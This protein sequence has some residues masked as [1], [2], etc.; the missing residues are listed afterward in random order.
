MKNK[1]P[2]SKKKEVDTKKLIGIDQPFD[3]EEVA[4]ITGP[5]YV[6][7]LRRNGIAVLPYEELKRNVPGFK[8]IEDRC[9]WMKAGIINFRNCDYD[10]DCNNCPFDHAMRSAMGEKDTPERME[11]QASWVS[12]L[13][14]RY[15]VAEKPCIHFKSGRIESPKE[16]AGNYE[17]YACHVHE[18]LYAQRQIQTIKKP[19]YTRVSGFQI[20]DNYYH[21]FGHSWAHMEHDG[22][23]RIGVD[24][25]ISKLLGPADVI[26]LPPV[27]VL[28]KQGEIGWL[29]TRNGL[30]APLQSPLSGTVCAVNNRIKEQPAI[31][32]QE[33][34]EAGWLFL[35]DPAS[36]KLNLKGLYYGK[37]CFQW[38]EKENQNLLEYLDPQYEQL[39]ATGGE[40]VDDIYTRLSEKSWYRLVC[41][42]LHTA[43]KG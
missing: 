27:G 2:K 33:P 38:I 43:E 34:Y 4:A 20:A 8:L 19:T 29:M 18:M 23:V 36:L 10:N 12:R 32:N 35:L 1:E 21:H 13:Q 37:E 31:A 40:L 6:Q 16:C 17:C 22:R 9:V 7:N 26:N 39:T 42:F 41:T 3:Y 24:A 25:F 28:L 5:E 30:K 15:Q 14:E 11:K